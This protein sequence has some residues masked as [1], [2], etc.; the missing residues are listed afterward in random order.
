[1]DVVLKQHA[2]QALRHGA[3]CFLAAHVIGTG[4]ACSACV[5]Y[6]DHLGIGLEE[7]LAIHAATDNSDPEHTCAACN[8]GRAKR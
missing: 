6:R 8:W 7:A 3:P 1:M 4:S 5:R 2:G